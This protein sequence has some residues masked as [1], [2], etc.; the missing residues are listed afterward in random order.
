M[1]KQVFIYANYNNI[2]VLKT[3][4]DVIKQAFEEEEYNCK[5]IKSV[6]G[7][8]KRA[9]IVV[10][11]GI[12]AFKFYIKGYRNIVLWQQGV[13]SEES[14]LRN[15]SKL[16]KK[17]LNL[18]DCFS[19]KKAKLVFYVSKELKKYYEKEAGCSFDYKAYIMPCFN[20]T[21]SQEE[22]Q[23][24]DYSKKIFTYVGSIDL[25]QCFEETV[26]LYA[27]IEQLFPES[28]LKVLTFKVDE[29]KEI[30][31]SYHIKN[32]SVACVAKEQVKQELLECSYGF[33][34]RKNIVVNQV[35]TPTKFSSYLAAGVLPIYSSCLRD[36][37]SH[38]KDMDIA[39]AADDFES[40][41]KFVDEEH[42]LE[43]VKSE[44]KRIFGSYYNIDF[45]KEAIK[46]LIKKLD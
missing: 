13:T 21:F 6:E 18:I 24:K 35:A 27:K 33:I 29:A 30:I 34:L 40:V 43:K 41:I 28:F 36:F 26:Q 15:K 45:H 46:E 32:Y 31:D 12:D 17:I 4:L 25:W 37:Y 11:M 42:D 38:F 16:R 10:P 2:V 9:I 39:C 23:D 7:I 14:F 8:D 5:Y 22:I 3:Y 19:M 20:E 1:L 44:I